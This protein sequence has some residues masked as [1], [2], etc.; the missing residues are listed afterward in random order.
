MRSG[1]SPNDPPILKN[2]G[3]ASPCWSVTRSDVTLLSHFLKSHPVYSHEPH[4]RHILLL[5]E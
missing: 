5:H 4:L 2:M 1:F 3:K